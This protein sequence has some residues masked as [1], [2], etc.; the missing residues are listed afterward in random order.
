MA[1][2]SCSEYDIVLDRRDAAYYPGDVVSGRV[3]IT[4]T[5]AMQC[6]GIR[7]RLQG[8]AEGH[9]VAVCGPQPIVDVQEDEHNVGGVPDYAPI[10]PAAPEASPNVF[11]LPA[12]DASGGGTPAVAPGSAQMDRGGGSEEETKESPPEERAPKIEAE[13]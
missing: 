9:V 10:Y 6:R 12:Y 1:A 5:S 11:V 4:T 2:H 7:V 13:A 8:V 3:V